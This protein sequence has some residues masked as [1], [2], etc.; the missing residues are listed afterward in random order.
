MYFFV[1]INNTYMCFFDYLNL[2]AKLFDILRIT[3]YLM[4]DI[5]QKLNISKLSSYL[6]T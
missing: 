4:I 5:L 6:K 2:E 1:K 3:T